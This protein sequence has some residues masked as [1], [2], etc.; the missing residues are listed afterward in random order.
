MLFKGLADLSG[1]QRWRFYHALIGF[2][3][4]ASAALIGRTAGDSLFLTHFEAR[5]LRYMYPVSA[6]VAGV[7]AYGYGRLA[8]RLALDRLIGLAICL[9]LVFLLA[10]R[11]TLVVDSP[12]ARIAAYIVGDLVVNTPMLLFWSFAGR[13][14]DP[15]A[16]KRLFGLVGAGGTVACLVAG[17]TVRPVAA[18]IGT[19]NLLWPVIV[20]LA[21][22]LFIVRRVARHEG[23]GTQTPGPAS[24]PGSGSYRHLL[25][26]GQVRVLVSLIVVATIA[27]TLVDYQF[28]AAARQQFQGDAMAAFFGTFYGAASGLAL[29]FQVFLVHV[30]L[31]RGGVFLG[32]AIMPIGLIVT[33]VGSVVTAG[34]EWTIASKFVFQVFA[35]TIDS[36]A[37]QM[38]YLAVALQ[39]RGQTRALADG[40]GKPVAIALAG[41]FLVLGDGIPTQVLA[42]ATAVAA[43]VWIV[44][45]RLNHLA[46]VQAL[47]ASIGSHR[48]DASS[49]TGPIHDKVFED[50]LR[51]ALTTGSDEE[52]AYLLGVVDTVDQ[53]D[54][55]P[56][57]RALLDRPTP[58]IKISALDYLSTRG[59]TADRAVV[60]SHLTHDDP[61][62]RAA[63]IRALIALSDEDPLE[64]V[65][66]CLADPHPE[67]RAAAIACLIG[68]DLDRLLTAG[69]ALRDMLESDETAERIGAAR[70]LS[71]IER[72]GMVRPLARLL[73]DGDPE[74]VVAALLACRSQQD[75]L[76]IPVITPL[77]S[78][79]QI[80]H[81]AADTLKSFGTG[82]LDHLVPYIEL[83]EEEGAFEGAAGIPPILAEIGD[84]STI[85][86][87]AEAAAHSPDLALRGHA[88]EALTQLID[89]LGA[90]ART[91]ET[92]TEL[93]GRELQAYTTSRIHRAAIAD[94]PNTEVLSDA[95]RHQADD[96]LTNALKLID[97]NTPDV[98]LLQLYDAVRLGGPQ[99]SSALEVFDNVVKGPIKADL[100]ACL[101][102]QTPTDAFQGDPVEAILASDISEW[103][104]IGALYASTETANTEIVDDLV[105]SEHTVVSETALFRLNTV[106]PDAAAEKARHMPSDSAPEIRR[107]IGDIL[108]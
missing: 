54:W 35:F 53:V 107:L 94:R 42:I 24:G 30:I 55:T 99:R 92:T 52:I 12:E 97:L 27:V 63:S 37:I 38:L 60:I 74:V 41:L 68:S 85:P 102:D 23:V 62:V 49:E 19:P 80:A 58:H 65:E 84:A 31:Q 8:G 46:Y 72:G 76:L 90:H 45:A 87:L 77:L 44:F 78:D 22:F 1:D 11:A 25:G 51:N 73:Q 95:L 36:A 32:L 64:E 82:V 98:D 106:N 4:V 108:K 88:I 69:A 34:F 18:V 103:I 20:L 57:Y 105:D 21:G 79:P 89:R 104:R 29:A 61:G 33:A 14:F 43:V 7:L 6:A 75:D 70:A 91:A 47:I 96:H 9:L 28:K 16:A 67:P 71:N 93:A 40:I 50:H 39:S 101:D 86:V 10:L 81:E 66:Q 3:C 56:E 59:K 48:F 100:L 5:H 2:A 17:L 83:S 15:R 13:L 26:T